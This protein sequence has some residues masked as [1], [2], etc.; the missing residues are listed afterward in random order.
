MTVPVRKPRGRPFKQGNPGRPP[1]SKNRVT[2]TLEQLAEGRAEQIFEK[3]SERALA[4][5]VS[6]LKL[7]LDRLWPPRKGQPVHTGMP[8]INTPQDLFP[9][10]A[11]IWTAIREGRLTPDE[12]SALSIVVDRSIQA[13]ELH[14]ITK[15]I[16]ALEEA[17]DRRDETKGPTSS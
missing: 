12:A 15:R 2:Q 5:D 7:L 4:G 8:P 11:S 9:A 10:I 17:R 1:G 3:V 6:C 13:I 16:A 14:N